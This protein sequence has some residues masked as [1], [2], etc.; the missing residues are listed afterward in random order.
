MAIKI[1]I[2]GTGQIGASIGLALGVHKD[3]FFRVGHDKNIRAANRAKAMGALDKVA[4]NL[5][6]SIT[7]AAI[8][9][10]AL[11][12]N[13]IYET[14]QSIAGD[15]KEDAIL[16]DTAPLKREI[17][18]WAAEL[19]PP[20]RY[21]IGLTPVIN[22]LYL[23]STASGV[24]AAHDD[25]FKNGLIA[26]YLPPDLPGEAIKLA[27]DF[28][29]LLGAEHMFID[30]V[31]L[32]S[33][34][35]ATHLLPQLVAAAYVNT[36]V[37]E[38]GWKDARKLTN[39][40]FASLSGAIGG[41]VEADSLT[42]QV[43]SNRENLVRELDA[44][45][46]NLDSLQQQLISGDEEKLVHYLERARLGHE[47]WLKERQAANWAVKEMGTNVELPT[48]RDVFARLISFGGRRKPQPPK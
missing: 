29:S 19:L 8:V 40:P 43:I 32:D 35:A 24:E 17:S 39:H 37:D 16:M 4:I 46:E 12:L 9:I 13:Q 28:S 26:I 36:T 30:P 23:E 14:L 22:P 2:I 44:V 33:M 1:T 48:V 10:L 27:S 15:L 25:L 5:S 21:Y 34:M 11:P 7:E 3:L 6:N 47:N 18:L 38:P 20:N 31:E 41:S 45:K 42:A